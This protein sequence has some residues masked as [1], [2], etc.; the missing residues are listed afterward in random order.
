MCVCTVC[1][2]ILGPDSAKE[3]KGAS[4]SERANMEANKHE[5]RIKRATW[6]GA[7]QGWAL[8]ILRTPRRRRGRGA[9]FGKQTNMCGSS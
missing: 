8:T 6:F 1:C 2:G 4:T 7:R 3:M 5:E 9:G